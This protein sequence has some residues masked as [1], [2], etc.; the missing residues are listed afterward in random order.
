MQ[1]LLDAVKITLTRITSISVPKNNLAYVLLFVLKGQVYVS[2]DRDRKF[3]QE[4]D[5]YLIKKNTAAKLSMGGD[6]IVLIVEL[7]SD[8]LEDMIEDAAGIQC[9]SVSDK[10]RD[11]DPLRSAL[12]NLAKSHF[13]TEDHLLYQSNLYKLMHL[14][15]NEYYHTPEYAD[16]DGELVGND[17]R[18]I[19]IRRYIRKNYRYPITMKDLAKYVHLTT[20]YLSRFIKRNSGKN[21]IEYLNEVRLRNA[22]SELLSTNN[23]ITSISFNHGFPSMT[24]FN[25]IFKEKYHE[26]P[27]KYRKKNQGKKIDAALSLNIEKMNFNRAEEYLKPHLDMDS[28]KPGAT[29]AAKNKKQI[30]V[31]LGEGKPV[32]TTWRELIN[33]GFAS[34]LLNSDFQ[35]QVLS[36]QHEL[37]FRYSRIEGLFNS[38]IIDRI[39]NTPHFNFSEANKILDFLLS[40]HFIPF[41]E[42]APKP[43]KISISTL[44]YLSLKME[45]DLFSTPEDWKVLLQGFINNCINRY[46]IKEVEKWKFEY[47]AHH[48]IHLEFTSEW[49]NQFL[50]YF[51]ISFKTIKSL[52]PEARIGGPGYNLSANNK[53]LSC[54]LE[55]LRKTGIKPD[56]ISVYSFHRDPPISPS[57]EPSHF[58]TKPNCLSWRINT[59]KKELQRFK[60]DCPIFITQWNFDYT[61]RNYLNDSTFTASFIVKNVLENMDIVSTVGYWVLSDLTADYADIDHIL[62]GGNGLVSINGLLKPSYYAYYFLSLLGEKLVEKGEN[63]IITTNGGNDYQI[64]LY[65]YCHPADYYCLC[66]DTEVNKDNINGIFGDVLKK[67]I[68]VCLKGILPGKYRIKK[69]TLNSHHGSV[70]DE[71]NKMTGVYDLSP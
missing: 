12:A 22:V 21:F 34:D 15:S 54:I 71:W 25:K 69:L 61:S 53:M 35:R 5:I 38:D 64:L 8:F 58:T 30:D 62:F 19:K 65:H 49:L 31:I 39:P 43:I 13:N 18:I 52:L 45:I 14:L 33:I 41:I 1:N 9:D 23:T 67:N 40:I 50:D 66:G 29:P 6:N 59:V 56:F 2:L 4:K 42:L 20:G 10:S 70:L 11:Y 37:N 7:P 17:K 55:G 26:T 27:L 47:W 16:L 44:S 63:Y 28:P 24:A 68:S 51:V 57:G 46:G 32:R 36:V 60:F 3:L 48:G